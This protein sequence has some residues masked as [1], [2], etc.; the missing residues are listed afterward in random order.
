[1][2]GTRIKIIL[3]ATLNTVRLRNKTLVRRALDTIRMPVVTLV[4][5]I[6]LRAVFRMIAFKKLLKLLI[7]LR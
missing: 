5:N 2:H 3:D 6:K 4:N 1:M 7:V